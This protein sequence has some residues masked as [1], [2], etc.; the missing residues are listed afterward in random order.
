MA[1][2]GALIGLRVPDVLVEDV[3]TTA[4]TIPDFVRMWDTMLAVAPR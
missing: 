2:A 1:T 3:A 4:K